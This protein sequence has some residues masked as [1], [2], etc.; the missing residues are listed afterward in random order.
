MAL[1]RLIYTSDRA[2]NCDDQEIKNILET[3][4][5]R[6][7]AVALTGVLVH[8]NNTFFQYLEGDKDKLMTLYEKI[9]LDSRHHNCEIKKYE[10]IERKLFPSWSMGYKDLG[11]QLAEFDSSIKGSEL[12]QLEKLIYGGNHLDDDGIKQLQEQ[13]KIEA[14][15]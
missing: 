11:T 15:G 10:P 6:N 9:K 3:C 2:E 8:S 5:Q 12:I 4:E 7:P 13:F 14:V 1:F